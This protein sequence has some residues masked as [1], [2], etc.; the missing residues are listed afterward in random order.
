M[1]LERLFD[2]GDREAWMKASEQLHEKLKELCDEDVL[3]I[4]LDPDVTEKRNAY[5]EFPEND[6]RY[7]DFVLSFDFAFVKHTD[8]A[9]STYKLC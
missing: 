4:C 5:I 2:N 1:K 7:A 6:D 9:P 3:L 8:S